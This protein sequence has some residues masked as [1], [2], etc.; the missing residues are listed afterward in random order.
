MQFADREDQE[1]A[2]G[3]LLGLVVDNL[4]PTNAALMRQ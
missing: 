1:D 4:V 3:L 2:K